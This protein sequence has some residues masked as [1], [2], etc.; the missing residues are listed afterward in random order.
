MIAQATRPAIQLAIDSMSFNECLRIVD[1][2]I[3]HVDIIEIGTP[4]I[5]FNGAALLEK[6]ISLSAGK[7]VLVDLKTMDA[8]AYE[9]DP[10]YQIGAEICTVLGTASI[11]TIQGVIGAAKKHNKKSQV[12]LINVTDMS[13]VAKAASDAGIDIIGIHTG[14][15]AQ[16]N[17]ST[18]FQD[19]KEITSLN[20][21]KKISVAGGINLE[22]VAMAKE[23]GADIVVI[24]GAITGSDNPGAMAAS[25]HRSLEATLL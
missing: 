24:G 7:P 14:I 23:L 19:L 21:G 25:I 13:S 18:P 22:T 12:D 15:D 8:G 2:C 17:G 1:Q 6:V 4:S 3:E 20:L 11:K 5:K 9:A 16:G 10:F